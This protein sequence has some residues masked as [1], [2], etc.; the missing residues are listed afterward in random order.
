[1]ALPSSGFISFDMIKAELGIPNQSPFSMITAA[2]GGYVAINQNSPSKPSTTAPFSIQDW[3]G[4][5]HSA[6]SI[7][8]LYFTFSKGLSTNCGVGNVY[9]NNTLIQGTSVEQTTQTLNINVGDSFYAQSV[10]CNAYYSYLKITSS[11]RGILYENYA[12]YTTQTS[13]TFSKLSNDESITIYM[14]ISP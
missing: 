2:Q 6:V 7:T 5:D 4:Y 11:T 1:M 3:Y 12:F 14:Y 8:K 9:I 13:P 10:I